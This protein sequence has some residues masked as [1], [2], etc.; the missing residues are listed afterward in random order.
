MG[1]KTS[2]EKFDQKP[3]RNY[4]P[5][6][7]DAFFKAAFADPQSAADLIRNFLPAS[8][9][10]RIEGAGSSLLLPLRAQILSRAL[11][12][13]AARQ[14]HYRADLRPAG[15]TGFRGEG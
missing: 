2:E 10:R 6:P 15:K 8:Y 11:G 9:S 1:Q 5:T 14:S 7:Y 3:E 4:T 13:A 12:P